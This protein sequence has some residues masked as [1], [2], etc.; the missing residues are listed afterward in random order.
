MFD[1]DEVAWVMVNVL[2]VV[3]MLLAVRLRWA[4]KMHTEVIV[5]MAS[6]G[7]GWRPGSCE[8]EQMTLFDDLHSETCFEKEAA[9]VGPKNYELHKQTSM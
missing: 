7:E 6:L 4:V 3:E 8:Y 1:V 5:A 2:E 9:V